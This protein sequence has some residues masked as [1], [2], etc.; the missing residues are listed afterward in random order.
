[1][2]KIAV[3]LYVI[4]LALFVSGCSYMLHKGGDEIAN[5]NAQYA[6]R[7]AD[8]AEKIAAEITKKIAGFG[9]SKELDEMQMQAETLSGEARRAATSA[10]TNAR[11]LD[12]EGEEMP[13]MEYES[14]RN[15]VADAKS[16]TERSLEDIK[17]LKQRVDNYQPGRVKSSNAPSPSIPP[18]GSVVNDNVMTGIIQ[19]NMS[20]PAPVVPVVTPV[21]PVVTPTTPVVTP[22][23][24]PTVAPTPM[25]D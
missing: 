16:K 21:V 11:A 4:V 2:K 15:K 22:T 19:N 24:T 7:N 6:E 8:E 9:K 25:R 5:T 18:V 17:A 20:V 3:F 1:M 12:K 10:R 14:Y 23:V 13:Q